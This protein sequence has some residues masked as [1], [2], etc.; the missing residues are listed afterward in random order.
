MIMATKSNINRTQ[1][2]DGDQKLIDGLN[3]HNQTIT[4]LMIGGTSQTTAAIIAVLQKRIDSAKTVVSSRATWQS[5]VKADHDERAQTK[6]FV[7]GLR[8]ALQVAFAGSIDTLADFGL[9]PRKT[10]AP[11]TPEQKAAAAA[12]AKATRAARHTMGSKQKAK[13]RGAAPVAT[14]APAPSPSPAASPS[15]PKP[16]DVATSLVPGATPRQS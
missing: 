15:A 3:K 14:P 7:S 2:Q 16:T 12:K 9:K 11:R 10:R 4:S 1:Q 8:Q 6:V 5:E 13:V